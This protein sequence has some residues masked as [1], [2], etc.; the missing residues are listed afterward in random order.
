GCDSVCGD[1]SAPQ[2]IS[3][4]GI[5]AG[6]L[7][8]WIPITCP[9]RFVAPA[10][11]AIERDDVFE[12]STAGAGARLS[13]CRK[14]FCLS[15]RDSGTASIATARSSGSSSSSRITSR[16]RPCA[17]ASAE[18][19]PRSTAR[20]QDDSM[21]LRTRLRTLSSA[22]KSSV[23]S[24]ETAQ[25]EAIPRPIV[26]PPTTTI[27]PFITRRSIT[28]YPGGIVPKDSPF[29]PFGERQRAERFDVLLHRRDAGAGVVGPPQTFIGELFQPRKI[30]EQLLR[31]NPREIQMDIGVA[32]G[33]KDG[34]LHVERS[35]RV[36]ED[37]P[38]AREVH[39]HVVG[40][41][42]I[43]EPVSRARKDRSARVNHHGPAVLLRLCVDAG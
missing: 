40:R 37:Q 5:A 34:G 42:R 15:S 16:A 14:I 20:F 21:S 3:T 28:D 12:A 17:A 26:P 8:K 41:H 23:L 22:S 11:A 29:R 1:V 32:A 24:P 43:G 39:G 10:I 30:L 35:A 27:E 13:S 9:G 18:S 36:R 7:K 25:I 4:S 2:T 19:F 31:R 38:Q 6:G 33:E